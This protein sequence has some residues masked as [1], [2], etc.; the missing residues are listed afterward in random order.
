MHP[1]LR[2]LR[3]ARLKAVLGMIT[4]WTTRAGLAT[5]RALFA[6]VAFTAALA[7]VTRWAWKQGLRHYSGASA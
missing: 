7:A 5:A 4:F 6:A 1:P 2:V 3:E